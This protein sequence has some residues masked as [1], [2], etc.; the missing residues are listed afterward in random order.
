MTTTQQLRDWWAPPCVGPFVK[1]ELHGEGAVTVRPE[2]LPA[3]AALD[4]CL[5]AHNYPTRQ[6]DTGAY[7]CRVITGGKKY[8]LHAYRIALDL[9]WQTNPYGL[10]LVTDMP[11]EMVADIKAIRTRSGK[12]VWR[13]GGDYSGNKDAMHYEITCS[14]QDLAT[15]IAP[16]PQEDDLV[17]DADILKIAD[18]VTKAQ[19]RQFDELK[20]KINSTQTNLAALERRIH[21]VPV[22]EVSAEQH[23]ADTDTGKRFQTLLG[24]G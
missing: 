2:I 7:N 15:G 20:A 6:K 23:K 14:P 16:P 3:V 11:A 5:K 18:A 13:W 19:Q 1:V 10:V 24:D 17:T 9:N 8:S 22:M 4:A 12:Q 21:G